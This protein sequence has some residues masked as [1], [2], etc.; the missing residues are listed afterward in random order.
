MSIKIESNSRSFMLRNFQKIIEFEFDS[1]KGKQ[2]YLAASGGKDS[3]TLSHLLLKS[4]FPHT[5]LHC[6]FQLRGKESDLDEKFLKNYTSKENLEIETAHFDTEIIAHKNRSG[7]Q[8]VARKLR[9][10]WFNSFLSNKN[11]VLMTAH[12]LDDSIETFF[13]NLM[14]GTS[15]KGLSGIPKKR[16]QIIRPLLSFSSDEINK[17][18]SDNGIEYRQDQSNFDSKYLRNELREN[19]IPKL[20]ERSNNFHS[21][22][23]KTIQSLHEINSWME[24]QAQ[25]FRDMYFSKRVDIIE[26]DKELLIDQDSIFIEFLFNKYGLKRSNRSDFERFIQSKTGSIFVTNT[27][28]FTVD[29]KHILIASLSALNNFSP[30]E[31][32]SIPNEIKI[33]SQNYT[34]RL[35]DKAMPFDELNN[36]LQLNFDKIKLPILIRKWENGDKIQP[37]GMTGNKLI[38]NILIDKKISLQEKQ[39][40]LLVEDSNNQTIAILNHM[41]SDKVKLTTE[42]SKILLVTRC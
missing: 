39:T 15:I 34:F 16:N 26:I 14:R 29:R 4:N 12:H 33:G 41:V 42:T 17:Y 23:N 6:N 13:I 9:Y 8:E 5:L 37:L 3:M 28:T 38:S 31:I 1:L 2:I 20:K 21:K 30:L 27:H 7:I 36:D 24:K 19:V 32:N 40:I 22:V 18:V 25:E 35:I 10:E 11:A